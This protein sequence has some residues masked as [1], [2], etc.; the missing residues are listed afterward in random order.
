MSREPVVILAADPP[1][2][3]PV[4]R[5]AYMAAGAAL[6]A[7]LVLAAVPTIAPCRLRVPPAQ[8]GRRLAAAG[9]LGRLL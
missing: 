7:V 1:N 4:Q 9:Q 8:S 3:V 5:A 6:G 2:L